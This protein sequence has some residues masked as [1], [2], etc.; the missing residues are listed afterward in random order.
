MIG[1]YTSGSGQILNYA[2]K[3]AGVNSSFMNKKRKKERKKEREERKKEKRERK[4]NRKLKQ[5]E[6]VRK[7]EWREENSEM[8]KIEKI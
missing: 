2:V 4:N 7:I 8:K 1:L 3:M 6:T 5:W